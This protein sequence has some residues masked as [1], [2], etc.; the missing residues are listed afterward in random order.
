MWDT[1]TSGVGFSGGILGEKKSK[2]CLTIADIS[3][4]VGIQSKKNPKSNLYF[5]NITASLQRN[6]FLLRE[7]K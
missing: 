2:N 1:R 3:E 5:F 4:F 7:F 6:G